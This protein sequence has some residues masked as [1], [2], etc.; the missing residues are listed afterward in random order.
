ML[1][2]WDPAA[3]GEGYKEEQFSR[4][5]YKIMFLKR[6]DENLDFEGGKNPVPPRPFPVRL[7]FH[8]HRPKPL[9]NSLLTRHHFLIGK[10]GVMLLAQGLCHIPV[11][12]MLVPSP[13]CRWGS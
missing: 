6:L 7:H 13:S 11:E 9:D 2:C 5:L 1:A 8:L 4:R 12:Y 10:T 3:L